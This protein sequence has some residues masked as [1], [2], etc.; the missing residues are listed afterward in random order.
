MK[1]EVL[2]IADCPHDKAVVERVPD[3]LRTVNKT[4][5]SRKSKFVRIPLL[6]CGGL[7]DHSPCASTRLNIEPEARAVQHFGLRCHSYTEG[8]GRSGLPSKELIRHA[9]EEIWSR[10]RP[11]RRFRVPGCA[12]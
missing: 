8:D 3:V 5:L 11:E 7:S 4:G 10:R 9:L 12:K 6:R 1:I 2:Y